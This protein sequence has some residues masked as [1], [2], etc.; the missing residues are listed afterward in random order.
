MRG[1]EGNAL[2]KIK[3]SSGSSPHSR[4]GRR[5]R[6]DSDSG[7]ET[8][9]RSLELASSHSSDDEESRV[10]RN[11]S[12]HRSSAVCSTSYLPNI[13]EHVTTPPELH[14]VQS[15]QVCY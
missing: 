5:H 9:G 15:P 10:G 1:Y 13:T 3:E 14:V 8:D 4:K 11:S 2:R 7:S 6:R 12:T